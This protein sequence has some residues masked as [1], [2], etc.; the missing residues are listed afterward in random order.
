M[1]H[2]VVE[3][4]GSLGPLAISFPT[5]LQIISNLKRKAGFLARRQLRAEIMSNDFVTRSTKRVVPDPSFVPERSVEKLM[6]KRTTHEQEPCFGQ[7]PENRNKTA[8]CPLFCDTISVGKT[9]HYQSRSN[10]EL[11][12][13]FQGYGIPVK[14]AA[15]EGS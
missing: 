4:R 9:P 14:T 11:W 5:S 10:K 1:R 12:D 2:F 15:T 8:A 3:P 7:N 6:A 13:S